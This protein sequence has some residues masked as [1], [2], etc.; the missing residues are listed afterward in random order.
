[1]PKSQVVYLALSEAV[2]KRVK[3]VLKGF[4][5]KVVDI[6]DGEELVRVSRESPP[7]LILI[8]K[9]IPKL[10]GYAAV[11]ILKNT[12]KTAEIPV[13]GICKCVSE[14]EAE[15]A[16]DSGCDDYVCYPF[17]KEEFERI[18]EKFLLR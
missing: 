3:E 12:K 4:K 6:P 1:M 8:E 9:E 18:L 2:G 16:R 5:C 13:I 11:L 7:D 14:S 15:S 10:D 17:E